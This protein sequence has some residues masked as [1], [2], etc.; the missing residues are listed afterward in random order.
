MFIKKITATEFESKQQAKAMSGFSSVI[1]SKICAL[2]RGGLGVPLIQFGEIIASSHSAKDYIES[3]SQ[4][5]KYKIGIHFNESS[6]LA[7]GV[8]N[9]FLTK[10]SYYWAGGRLTAPENINNTQASNCELAFLKKFMELIIPMIQSEVSKCTDIEVNVAEF[11]DTG[12]AFKNNQRIQINTVNCAFKDESVKLSII[13]SFDVLNFCNLSTNEHPLIKNKISCD[14]NDI[15]VDI[16]A[17]LD[18]FN[19]TLGD[20]KKLEIG[21]TLDIKNSTVSLINKA[22][23]EI[24]GYGHMGRD[25]A[26]QQLLIKIKNKG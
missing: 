13:T 12:V 2:S 7:I 1:A 11:N 15:S 17:R 24:I 6:F 4:N 23:N 9:D 22:G 8:D 26:S 19:M 18:T 16:D 14:L 5:I 20:I 25:D 21:Q 3:I 10:C